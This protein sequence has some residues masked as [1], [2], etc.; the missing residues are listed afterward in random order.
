MIDERD[1]F[2]VA[3]QNG[4][5]SL[6][7]NEGYRLVEHRYEPA[8]FGNALARYENPIYRLTFVRDRGQAFLSIGLVKPGHESY[9]LAQLVS[10]L[11]L[12]S[13]WS[14]RA[15]DD[16]NIL[17]SSVDWQ[18]GELR[19]VMERYRNQLFAPDLFGKQRADV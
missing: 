19:R 8:H 13:T 3:V 4:F 10:F 2:L 17:Y 12:S 16:D 11:D 14:Y 5:Q 6:L 18:V 1:P 15:P 9:D 7:N